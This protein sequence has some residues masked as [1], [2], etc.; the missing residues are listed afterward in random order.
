MDLTDGRLLSELLNHGVSRRA[1]LKF[2]A[3]MAATLALPAAYASKI[4]SESGMRGRRSTRRLV[5][6]TS[7]GECKDVNTTLK[8][9]LVTVFRIYP[10]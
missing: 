5:A 10:S 3:T 6:I 9:L 4:S 8:L 2:S 1:F 7:G